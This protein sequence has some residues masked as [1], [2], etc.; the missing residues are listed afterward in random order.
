MNK[1]SISSGTA[2]MIRQY[3]SFFANFQINYLGCMERN[4]RHT[5]GKQGSIVSAIIH[6]KLHD[7]HKE[8]DIIWK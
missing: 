2:S 5:S 7:G 3:T 1:Q 4:T 8:P 6:V